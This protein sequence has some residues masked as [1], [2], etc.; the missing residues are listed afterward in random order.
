MRPTSCYSSL[1]A[2][3]KGLARAER[4]VRF[5]PANEA[6]PVLLA[7][8]LAGVGAGAAACTLIEAV[9]AAGTGRALERLFAARATF[10]LSLLDA[11]PRPAPE[12]PPRLGLVIDRV[13]TLVGPAAPALASAGRCG[14]DFRG[15]LLA[16]LVA[17]FALI[18]LS[19]AMRVL[20]TA[21]ITAGV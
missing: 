10:S 4:G 8:A 2:K 17:L 1:R 12:A 11:A 3:W 9:A 6:G 16:L 15:V 21:G 14:F 5:P 20:V 19:L 13:N 18:S 7:A